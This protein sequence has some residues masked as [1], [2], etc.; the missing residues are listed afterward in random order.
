MNLMSMTSRLN[1]NRDSDRKAS[2]H[3]HQSRQKCGPAPSVDPPDREAA[4]DALDVGA[5]LYVR[6]TAF[7]DCSHRRR[8]HSR[9]IGSVRGRPAIVQQLTVRAEGKLHL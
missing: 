9:V 3:R 2:K 1:A 5:F 4:R 7:P 6:A 8:L